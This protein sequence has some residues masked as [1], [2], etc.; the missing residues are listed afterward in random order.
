MLRLTKL[1]LACLLAAIVATPAANANAQAGQD[2]NATTTADPG[3]IKI[4]QYKYRDMVRIAKRD[5]DRA[6]WRHYHEKLDTKEQLGVRS[7][8]AHP[9]VTVRVTDARNLDRGQEDD[10]ARARAKRSSRNCQPICSGSSDHRKLW[11]RNLPRAMD[12]RLDGGGALQ[13]LPNNELAGLGR[14]DRH[15]L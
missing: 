14:L 4:G 6:A 11:P 8:M 7:A 2:G 10:R 1:I 12:T 3:V 9:K 15:G 5:G 13:S